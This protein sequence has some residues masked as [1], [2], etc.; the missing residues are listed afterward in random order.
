M[1]QEPLRRLQ[2]DPLWHGPSKQELRRGGSTRIR[3]C[4]QRANKNSEET[5]RG[6][7]TPVS[8]DS[9]TK[10]RETAVEAFIGKLFKTLQPDILQTLADLVSHAFTE[11]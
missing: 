5:I 6:I 8:N 1:P 3:N 10:N 7:L 4:D 2:E 11:K 9:T